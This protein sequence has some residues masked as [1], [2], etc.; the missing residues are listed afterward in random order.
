MTYQRLDRLDSIGMEKMSHNNMK[1]SVRFSLSS[2]R[3]SISPFSPK[4]TRE[5]L[6][7]RLTSQTG[8]LV[9]SVNAMHPLRVT[10]TKL[11]S[12]GKDYIAPR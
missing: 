1:L 3:Y 4:L 11:S 9:T 2:V 10:F 7:E 6:F 5:M 12:Q 8:N